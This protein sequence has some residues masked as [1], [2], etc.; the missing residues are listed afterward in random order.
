MC[1]VRA[2]RHLTRLCIASLCTAAKNSVSTLLHRLNE[3][4]LLYR[5]QSGALELMAKTKMCEKMYEQ[6]GRRDLTRLG[7]I[8]CGYVETI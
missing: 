6:T 5:A 8:C 3:P 1:T 7:T 2:P 4:S